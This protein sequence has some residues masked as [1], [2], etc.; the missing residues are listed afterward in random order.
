MNK[1]LDE[2]INS[3]SFFF[4]VSSSLFLLLIFFIFYL[5]EN[6]TKKVLNQYITRAV[7]FWN[8]LLSSF[9][10]KSIKFPLGWNYLL[11]F[12][13]NFLQ[14]PLSIKTPS[15][16]RIDTGENRQKT[17]ENY[18]EYFGKDYQKS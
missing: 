3:V 13:C 6:L 14:M 17:E 12:L 2:S 10:K 4:S 1:V 7:S 5:K 16:N 15:E 8:C 18:G 11:V 9:L